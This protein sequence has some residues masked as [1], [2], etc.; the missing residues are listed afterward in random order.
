M[1]DGDEGDREREGEAHA[2]EEWGEDKADSGPKDDEALAAAAKS[3][4]S[5]GKR[6]CLLDAN[7]DADAAADAEEEEE[8]AAPETPRAVDFDDE[9]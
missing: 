8:E 5:D 2:E 7:A 4:A 1:V 9:G 6:F 3:D